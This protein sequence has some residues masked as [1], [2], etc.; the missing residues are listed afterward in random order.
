MSEIDSTPIRI[1]QYTISPE[2]YQKGYRAGNSPCTCTSVCCQNGV[3]ADVKERDHILA[4][5]DI[6]KKYLD[7]TQ[8]PDENRWFEQH[9]QDDADFVSGR[10]VGT[11]VV[12]GK[13]ALLNKQGHCSLQVAA[14]QEGMHRWALKPV[15]CVLFPLEISNNVIAFDDLLDQEQQCC[16]VSS[17]FDVPIFEACKDELIHIIGED[18]YADLDRQYRARARES[19]PRL[20]ESNVA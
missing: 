15:F 19:V 4:H 11:E 14:T 10:S 18:G 20:P 8:T 12:N 3:Y 17:D 16:T 9:E 13:C 1:K 6:I 7:E 2:L 5:K